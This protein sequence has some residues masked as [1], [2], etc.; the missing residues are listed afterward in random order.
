MKIAPISNLNPRMQIKH[1]ESTKAENLTEPFPAKTVIETNSIFVISICN[2]FK[3]V[4]VIGLH[5][6]QFGNNW[7][8]RILRGTA[9]IGR[10]CRLSLIWLTC[11]QALFQFRVVRN[12]ELPI[13]ASDDIRE[14]MGEAKNGPDCRLHCCKMLR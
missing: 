3:F 4:Y 14:H 2:G 12:V 11:D 9:K 13:S 6:V 10:G 5:A 8:R 7:M 1:D